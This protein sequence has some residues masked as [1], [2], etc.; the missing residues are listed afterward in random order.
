M[1]K[2]KIPHGMY[3]KEF[4]EDAVRLVRE[5]GLSAGRAAERLSMPTSNESGGSRPPS[6]ESFMKSASHNDRSARLKS[7]WHG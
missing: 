3:T 1:A 2:V 7:S 5:G 6:K 4:R